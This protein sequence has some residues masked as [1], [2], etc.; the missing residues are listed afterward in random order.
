MAEAAQTPV[1]EKHDSGCAC[2]CGGSHG[3]PTGARDILDRRYASGERTSTLESVERGWHFLT[4]DESSIRALTNAAGFRYKWDDASKQYIHPAG[5]TILTPS[6]KIARYFFGIDY[7][8]KVLKLSLVEASQ[9]KIG[10]ITDH[11][12][13]YCFHY[14]ATTGKYG[15]TVM[16][17]LRIAG[18]VT[19]VAL[20]SVTMRA[21]CLAT[22]SRGGRADSSARSIDSASCSRARC[23]RL[24]T[25]PWRSSSNS[26]I[27]R[28]LCPAK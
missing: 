28:V 9:N 22:D 26:A 17:T 21:I 13:L 1:K 19:V 14:D 10:T 4:G 7:E 5:I 2:S 25:A 3:D 16:R 12:L 6:G 23:R 15:L 18:V 27:S 8:P 20:V 24:S 11:V